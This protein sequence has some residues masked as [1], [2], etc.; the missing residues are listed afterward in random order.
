MSRLENRHKQ[1][2][3]FGETHTNAEWAKKFGLA[4]N[5]M[6]RYLF[7]HGLT[8]EEVARLRGIKYPTDKAE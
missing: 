8:V 5:V 3:G 4:R 6:W 2:E 7:Q 1:F